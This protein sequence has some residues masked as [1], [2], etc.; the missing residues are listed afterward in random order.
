MTT[1]KLYRF[2]THCLLL[3]CLALLT[4]CS[5]NSGDPAEPASG[6]GQAQPPA[7]MLPAELVA[8]PN[9]A[10]PPPAIMG[11]AL[12][13]WRGGIEEIKQRKLIR[14]LVGYSQ[15]H[16]F[17]DGLTTRGITADSLREFERFLQRRLNIPKGT[18]TI[19]T[20]PVARDQM[21][22]LLAQGMGELA[23]GNLTIT[24]AR[25]DRVDFS[26]PLASGIA[27]VVVSGPDATVPEH[28]DDLAGRSVFIRQSSSFAESVN[29][30]NTDFASRGLPELTIIAANEN[31]QTEDILELVNAGVVDLTIADSYL[32]DFWGS[33]LPELSVHSE[34]ALSQD[35][36]IGWAIRKDAAGLKPLVDEFI[37]A[38]RKGTLLGNILFKRYLRDNRYIDNPT[39][40][41]DRQ[42]LLKLSELFQKY[43]DRY[44]FDWLLIAAQAYQE[45][46]LIHATRS[47]AGA[48]GV[49]QILPRTARGPAVGIHNVEELEAN[50]H[51]GH[52]YLR[53]II[54]EY[55][56]DPE[57]DEFNRELLAFAAY[58]AGPTRISR[59][60]REAARRGLNPNEW[61]GNVEIVVAERV[62]RETV[63]YVRNILKYYTTYSLLRDREEL[64]AQTETI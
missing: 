12:E 48:V 42:R 50:I 32:A 33:V 39:A 30:L 56:S 29:R 23:I 18:L 62:G 1:E 21:L 38:N 40:S 45:S 19:L 5:D 27:E 3:S 20:I 16:Y 35:G 58:N 59:L 53:H 57:L 14:V 15:T 4:A 44:T 28:L 51:A 41:E 36:N 43:S 64:A 47:A 34:L 24:D 52:K 2:V 8:D 25:L 6:V 55:F 7:D 31:L 46:R 60:R 13:P 17:L 22:D 63:Q 26:V 54:D 9:A 10:L 61:F 37:S 49:M 11:S